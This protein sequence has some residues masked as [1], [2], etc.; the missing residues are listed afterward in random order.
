MVD[1][2]KPL[3]FFY[4]VITVAAICVVIAIGILLVNMRKKAKGK[5]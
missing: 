3:P 5:K 1:F 2:T 4:V